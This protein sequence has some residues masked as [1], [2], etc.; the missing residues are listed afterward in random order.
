M[1]NITALLLLFST[2]ANSQNKRMLLV[3]ADNQSNIKVKEQ[4]NVLKADVNGLNERDIEVR[5][6]YANN[7]KAAFK[8]RKLTAPFTVI[9]VGKDGGD[10]LK[11]TL[12]VS[13]KKLFDTIDGMPMRKYEMQRKP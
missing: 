3:F 1:L 6:Y 4:Q 7:D 12:P 2:F 11:S 10:K 8:A 13:L 9:L 5:Y